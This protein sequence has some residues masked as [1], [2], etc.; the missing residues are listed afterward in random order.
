MGCSTRGK[1]LDKL[2]PGVSFFPGFLCNHAAWHR[3]TIYPIIYGRSSAM[4]ELCGESCLTSLNLCPHLY[5]GHSS[6]LAVFLKRIKQDEC[7]SRSSLVAWWLGFWAFTAMTQVQSLV[8]ELTSRKP[9]KMK[10]V[11]HRT[12]NGSLGWEGVTAGAGSLQPPPW[13]HQRRG[14]VCTNVWAPGMHIVKQGLQAANTGVGQQRVL[15]Q[16]NNKTRRHTHQISLPTKKKHL[17]FKTTG[18]QI[19]DVA[20]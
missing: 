17:V 19:G 11:N 5:D 6:A 10:S 1:A 8:G 9:K 13:E 12:G 4:Q 16:R 15:L 18:F 7:E 2:T 20:L 3:E 14:R